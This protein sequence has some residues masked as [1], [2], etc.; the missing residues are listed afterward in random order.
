MVRCSAVSMWPL[1]PVHTLHGDKVEFNMVEVD[2]VALAPYTLVTKSTVSATKSTEL[3]TL[4]TATSCRIQV[5]ADLLPKPATKSTVYGDSRL[6]CRFVAGFGN[7]RLCRQCVPGYKG[8]T[9]IWICNDESM[10]SRNGEE[11]FPTRRLHPDKIWKLALTSTANPNRPRWVFFWKTVT[12]PC[13]HKK[14]PLIFFR[15]NFYKY[16]RIFIMF[17]AQ[18]HKEMPKSLA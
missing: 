1:S 15:C 13:P 3:A 6:C 9:I 7:N 8:L 14:V 4:S 5:V 17:R 12:T 10:K 2:R 16:W 18:L 11:I